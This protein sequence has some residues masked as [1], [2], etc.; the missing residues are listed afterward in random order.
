M[1]K[2]AYEPDR[3]DL[4]EDIA[5]ENCR[6]VYLKRMTHNYFIHIICCQFSSENELERNWE[7]LVGNVSGAIQKKIKELIEIY[8]VYIVFFQGKI[9]D[10]LLYKIEQNKY[11]SR[12][13]VITADMP[14]ERSQLEALV[15]AKLFGLKIEQED[16]GQCCLWRKTGIAPAVPAG[17]FE[18]E[19]EHYIGKRAREKMNEQ[20]K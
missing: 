13:I 15:D 6:I 9:S 17:K 20:N 4:R 11:S 7:E 10:A 12:K 16:S 8:N 2:F 18:E 5:D 1:T 19:L 3:M 14:A